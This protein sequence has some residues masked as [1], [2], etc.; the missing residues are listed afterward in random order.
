LV[1]ESFIPG[2]TSS[3]DVAALSRA[4]RIAAPVAHG[5][6]PESEADLCIA[7]HRTQ[8]GLLPAGRGS[9]RAAIR[10]AHEDAGS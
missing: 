8:S 5:L 6:R 4:M 2:D 1:R 9:D 7:M 10:I 3:A